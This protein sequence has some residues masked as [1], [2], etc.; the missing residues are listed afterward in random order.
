MDGG[1]EEDGALQRASMG[2]GLEETPA[3]CPVSHLDQIRGEERRKAGVGRLL[4]RSGGND[5][6]LQPENLGPS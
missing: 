6:F 2:E 5:A 4:R 3:L 1:R